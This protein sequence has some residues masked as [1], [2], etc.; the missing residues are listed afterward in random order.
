[1]AT[2]I[3]PKTEWRTFF[4]AF[5]KTVAGTRVEVEAASLALGDQIVADWLPLVGITYDSRDDLLDI[6]MHGAEHLSH[7][8]RHPRAI[9]V[10]EEAGGIKSIAVTTGDGTEEILTFKSPLLLPQSAGA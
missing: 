10:Q 9:A 4:D 2:R 6:S 5:S 3:V 1:M 8:I 7:L